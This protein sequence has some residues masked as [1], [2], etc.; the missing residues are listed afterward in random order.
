[1]IQPLADASGASID[2]VGFVS[3]L[4]IIELTPGPNMAWLAGL[5][6][7]DGRRAGLAATA[8]IALGLAING[9][10]A[11]LGLVTLIAL[12]HSVQ[13]ALRWAGAAL[14]VGLAWLT[15]RDQ[16]VETVPAQ[17]S[18]RSFGAGLLLNLLNPKAFL[19]FVVVV[20]PFLKGGTL[21]AQQAL[22]LAGVSTGVATL[23]HLG[24]VMAAAPL[25]VWASNPARTRRVRQT[26]AVLMLGVALAFV[27][28]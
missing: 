24:I 15:W 2:W 19:F 1:M 16:A 6:V 23:V 13:H 7:A 18:R 9:A 5:S 14:M 11:A 21:T 25:H 20:P 3:A 27:L 22:V 8:G 12:D 28:Q 26:M 4:L 10:F 17:S